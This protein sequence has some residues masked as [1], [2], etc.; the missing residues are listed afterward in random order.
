MKKLLMI[1]AMLLI[2]AL[3]VNAQT[4][5]FKYLFSVNNNG[6]KYMEEMFK[7]DGYWTFANNKSVVYKSDKNGI[8]NEYSATFTYKETRDG[9]YVFQ[10]RKDLIYFNSDFS[11]MNYYHEPESY[12][13][14][15]WK[16][17]TQ[18]LD[19]TDGPEEQHAPNQ[20]Y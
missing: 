4:Y 9:K 14:G 19:R 15:M 5:Y 6:V 12:D 16:R 2:G 20:F 8:I 11:R 13:T 7:Q 3:S 10:Y 17:S 1:S 18:A